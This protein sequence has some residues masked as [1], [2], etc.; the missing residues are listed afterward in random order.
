MERQTLTI[1]EAA[2]MLGIAKNTVYRAVRRGEIPII[3]VGGRL[4]VPRA[5]MVQLLTG[6]T[7]DTQ[8]Y[9]PEAGHAEG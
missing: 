8:R 4:L 6:D 5:A 9:K 7:E 1:C 3:R 2:G